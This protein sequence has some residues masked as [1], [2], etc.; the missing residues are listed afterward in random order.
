MANEALR[1]GAY[2]Q[3]HL[4][5]AL[6]NGELV[7]GD[8]ELLKVVVIENSHVLVEFVH[9]VSTYGGRH[10]AWMPR[11]Y[12]GV[13]GDETIASAAFPV[14]PTKLATLVRESLVEHRRL[15]SRDM[16]RCFATPETTAYYAEY[17]KSLEAA[18]TDAQA[19]LDAGER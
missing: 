12:F 7:A 10:R 6:D 11:A 2:F 16:A 4:V 15:Q 18:L 14:A 17:A 13:P 8:P 3:L 9:V 5:Q 1:P 19:R